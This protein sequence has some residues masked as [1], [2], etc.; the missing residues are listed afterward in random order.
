M[1]N[2]FLLE[3]VTPSRRILSREVDSFTAIN[4]KGEFGILPSH[5]QYLTILKPG[6]ITRPPYWLRTP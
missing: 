1:A 5:T 2:T 4:G 3:I 6:E